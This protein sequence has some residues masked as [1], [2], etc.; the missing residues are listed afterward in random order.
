MSLKIE[1]TRSILD[2]DLDFFST[3][4]PFKRMFLDEAEYDL[5][6]SVYESK[7]DL[8][9]DD[10]DFDSKYDAFIRN[11]KS[12]LEAIYSALK[13]ESST[14]EETSRLSALIAQ[15]ELDLDIL[16]SYGSGLDDRS[17]P[18]HV[19]SDDE[20][21]NMNASLSVFFR[22]YLNS[23]PP[24]SIVTIARSSLDDYCPPKQVDFI[25]EQTLKI[26]KEQ[27]NGLVN[28]VKTCY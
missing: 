4:D 19:S 18:D 10:A 26:V 14:K 24:P 15:R 11:K 20:I 1:I 28:S 25:Q 9:K 3:M 12:K 27:W 8:L 2:I 21:V 7:I 23:A 16:H 22:K 13:S 5:F 17:L 6:K